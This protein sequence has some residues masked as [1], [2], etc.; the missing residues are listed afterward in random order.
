MKDKSPSQ[1]GK[2]V[3]EEERNAL[4]KTLSALD[5]NFDKAV[6]LILNTKGKVVVTGM[7][8]SGLVGKKIAATL[9][10]TGTPSF[11]L[12]PAEA[13]HGDL[14]M[15]SK[16]DIVLAI[17]NSGETPELLAIIPTIKRWG[18][19]VISIT[20][21]KNSTLAKESD[22]HL[23]LNIEREACPLNL[24]PTSS[25]TATL[26]LGD[27][28]AVALLEMRGFTA[29]DF[30]RFHPGGSLGRK[31]MRVSE[32]M[33]RGEELPVVHPET[34]LK[35]T[36]IVMSEKGFGA[37]LIINKDG[38][39]TGIITD[40][41]LRRFIKKGGSI[42]RSL[43]EEAM[44]VNPKYINKDILVVEALEI[45]ERYN[46]TVLPV[47]EDK[48]PVGLVHLHDILKSGVI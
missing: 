4:Q 30:A 15:I 21:N 7:G 16:E 46:I 40:G 31:L 5:N 37:A 48:K 32:I 47:V 42:D 26:A 22:I 11:F 24:A 43:T 2:K 44:T 36:V 38:D 39:L 27:A 29:E 19:K 1:I 33:H 14:G 45:M 6:E 9:A 13:I 28:L 10:S 25:S 34:E 3:L 35:E 20:N 12:H 18:N 8:K 41:D 17:S 23:Y